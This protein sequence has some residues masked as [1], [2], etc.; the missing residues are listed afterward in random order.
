MTA[1]RISTPV[2]ELHERVDAFRAAAN[3]VVL[4]KDREIALTL[5]SLLANGHLLIEDIPGVGKTTLV[6]AVSRLMGLEA[7]RIQ[8]TNDLLPADIIGSSVFDTE[9]KGFFF[10]RGPIF[11]QIVLADELNRATPKTQSA[12]LQA[13]EE[14]KISIDGVTHSLPDPFFM[15]ATQNPRQQVGTFPLPESQLDRFLMRIEL[16]YPSRAAEK[17]LLLGESRLQLVEDLKPIFKSNDIPQ[18]QSA[19]QSVHVSEHIIGYIQDLVAKSRA[20]VATGRGLSPRGALCLLH[21]AQA[22]AFLHRRPMVL[23]EDVQA[24]AIPVM[25]HRLNPVDDLTGETGLRMAEDIVSS[26]RVD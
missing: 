25:S 19:V 23:P 22:W 14:R 3:E 9:K 16:G 20:N 12:C 11:A 21:A 4:D 17:K 15:I 2:Q 24:V 26:V 6:K 18:L 8:F 5:C 13:M 10:H 7:S 1:A